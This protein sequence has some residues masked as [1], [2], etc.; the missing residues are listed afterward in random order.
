MSRAAGVPLMVMT[1]EQCWKGDLHRWAVLSWEQNINCLCEGI[2]CGV[3]VVS[4]DRFP[5]A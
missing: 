4:P 5:N 3:S 2:K 1:D